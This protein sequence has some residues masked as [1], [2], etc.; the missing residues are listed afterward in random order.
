LCPGADQKQRKNIAVLA[1]PPPT[2]P[3]ERACFFAS[4]SGSAFGVGWFFLAAAFLCGAVGAA[5]WLLLFVRG[6]AVS[7]PGGVLCLFLLSF[8]LLLFPLVLA[9][10]LISP[11][12][13][14]SVSCLLLLLCCLPVSPPGVVS[15]LWL[16]S[17]P[18]VPLPALSGCAL[19]V[20]L[21]V[22]SSALLVCCGCFFFPRR[23]WWF[24]LPPRFRCS[25]GGVRGRCLPACWS[26]CFC[27]LCGW[28]RCARFVFCSCRAWWRCSSLCVR[29]RCFL[30]C[31]FLVWL[32][33]ACRPCCSCR[34]CPCSLACWWCLVR[35]S[36][37][38]LAAPLPRRSCRCFCLCSLSCFSF[39]PRFFVCG[40]FC[41]L[42]RS[43]SFRLFLWFCRCSP[44]PASLCWCLG[45]GVSGW[46]GLLAVGSCRLSAVPFL[47]RR[48]AFCPFSA[49]QPF[50]S[51]P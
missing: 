16:W 5:G 44:C 33:L 22:V 28:R 43:S 23:F 39:F 51:S 20:F 11:A 6:G 12:V 30:W 17:L 15:L 2:R 24:P 7:S 50:R 18:L 38:P 34:W 9:W 27:R 13:L 14:W 42:C 25:A 49:G 26:F 48:G 41:C 37:C 19:V 46:F 3:R 32:C 1:A 10:C 40:W 45:P 47:G 8:F 29:R 31:W 4:S 21:L 36:S 35:S